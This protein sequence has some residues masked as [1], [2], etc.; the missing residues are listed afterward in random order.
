MDVRP[1]ASAAGSGVAGLTPFLFA[2]FSLGA[3]K[4]K[5]ILFTK[6]VLNELKSRDSVSANPH[7]LKAGAIFQHDI[8]TARLIFLLAALDEFFGTLASPSIVFGVLSANRKTETVTASAIAANINES[9]DVHLNVAAKVALHYEVVVDGITKFDNLVVRE[10]FRAGVG[11]DACHRQN[12]LRRG[13]PDSENVRE[14]V[15]DSLVTGQIYTGYTCHKFF[16]SLK[17]FIPDAVYAWDF[18]R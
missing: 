10:I 12:F 5:L 9:L 3:A 7:F 15:F 8:N 14:S 11:V 2:T 16:T 18:R 17:N 4:K 13:Q 1:P 6:I